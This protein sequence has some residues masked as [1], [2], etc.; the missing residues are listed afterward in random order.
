MN[1]VY[2]YTRL[3]AV[4]PLLIACS[5]GLPKSV[6][7][8][9]SPYYEFSSTEDALRALR[10]WNVSC[11]DTANCPSTVGQV[12][13]LIGNNV[14]VCTATLTANDTIVTNS[15]CFPDDAGSPQTVCSRFTS[16][17][18]PRSGQHEREV[19]GCAEV[20]AKSDI[21][22]GKFDRPD[23]MV[24]KLKKSLNRGSHSVS[25]EGMRDGE[26]LN[27]F[28]IDPT[29]IGGGRLVGATCEVLHGTIFFP[30]A[31][32]A[33]SPIQTTKSCEIVQ[34]NSGSSLLDPRGII[35]GVVFASAMPK[36]GA[37]QAG[38]LD[39]KKIQGL[40]SRLKIGIST[41]AA[42]MT[43]RFPS[44]G[45]VSPNCVVN[46]A[47]NNRRQAAELPAKIM[48]TVDREVQASLLA[49]PID[50][51]RFGFSLDSSPIQSKEAFLA[52]RAAPAC[53]KPGL[54]WENANQKYIATG[55]EW[56]IGPDV[57]DHLR[58]VIVA[59]SRVLNTTVELLEKARPN[60]PARVKV[61]D[62]RANSVGLHRPF[63]KEM[64]FPICQSRDLIAP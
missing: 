21:A 15:H 2:K 57:D 41:N 16:I 31:N 64:T 14:G 46:A 3:L 56:K 42:C 32:R 33:D 4:T 60:A 45:P 13:V 54:A 23:Y 52:V 37:R 7:T 18:F 11:A 28:K 62:D 19:V 47:E 51:S 22:D 1:L 10:Y 12:V 40:L 8:D 17:V 49:Q 38:G 61:T 35:R 26:K 5:N 39:Q 27:V 29:D 58:L 6:P 55:R 43:Y 30:H 59:K 44:A 36:S 53:L 25:R 50:E 63:V 9:D 20:L 48:E 34:G 24:L